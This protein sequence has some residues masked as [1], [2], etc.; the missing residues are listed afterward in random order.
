[1]PSAVAPVPV[2]Q[3]GF[4]LELSTS[5]FAS[6]TLAGGVFLGGRTAGGTILGGSFDYAL[7]SATATAPSADSVTTSAQALRLGAGVR[8][9]F[10]R[11]ADRRLDLFGAM[12]LSFEHRSVELP[13]AT[14][15]TSASASGFSLALGPGLRLWVHEQIAIG[16]AARLRVTYL[17]GASGA[18]TNG[19]DPTIDTTLTSIAFDGTFQLLGVF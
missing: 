8:Q 3:S 14:V 7:T 16:Y 6:G 17:S 4:A 5:G 2:D 11:S 1:V 19:V 18:L 10:A 9:P 15:N 13:G 12:D